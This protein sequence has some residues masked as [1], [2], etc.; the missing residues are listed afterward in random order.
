MKD[1]DLVYELYSILVHNGTA[2]HGHY[3]SYI[4]SEDNGRWFCFNDDRVTEIN[5]LD[6]EKTFGGVG[7]SN[8]YALSYRQVD[9][10]GSERRRAEIPSYIKE[11]ISQEM[12]NLKQREKQK[13]ENL[14]NIIVL[15]I[16][17]QLSVKVLEVYRSSTL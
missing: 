17:Y 15:K 8:A 16:Y 14:E 7:H 6:I 10:K 13:V 1:G 3:F 9:P 12:A 2:N 4:K 11:N 5:I